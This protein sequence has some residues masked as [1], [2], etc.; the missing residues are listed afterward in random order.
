MAVSPP[1]PPSITLLAP[2]FR[3]PLLPSCFSHTLARLSTSCPL[4]LLLSPT[5]FH[6]R[7]FR[8]RPQPPSLQSLVLLSSLSLFHLPAHRITPSLFKTISL[9]RLHFFYFSFSFFRSP[10]LCP[11]TSD[12]EREKDEEKVEGSQAPPCHRSSLLTPSVLPRGT[13]RVVGCETIA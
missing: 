13:V 9:R 11:P 10:F 2:C 6:S 1:P 12:R 7:V 8:L 4:H 3:F 5:R